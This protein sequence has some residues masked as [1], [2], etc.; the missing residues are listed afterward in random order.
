MLL[1]A[2]TADGLKLE[3]GDRAE[4]LLARGTRRQQLRT[5]EVAGLFTRLA[6]FP[7]GVQVVANLGFYTQATGITETD[8]FLVSTTEEGPAGQRAAA[9][10]I[11]AG[12]GAGDRLELD[13]AA[14][15]LNREQSSLTALN[16]R[17][18]LGLDAA[19]ALAMSAAVMAIFVLGLMLHRRAEFVLL[20]AQGLPAR[21]LRLLLLGEA[22]FVALAGLVVGGVAGAGLGRLLVEVLQP[23]FIR[24][25]QLT[26]AA[27]DLLG[28]VAIVLAATAV[29]V[30]AAL[31]I[32][33][34]L[35]PGE[36]LREQ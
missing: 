25:P 7:E 19:F 13:T 22:V 5:V 10:A 8:T 32:L 29:S 12:P 33:R 15:G 28:F 3:V 27:G 21:R 30:G 36:V 35:S 26:L 17:G 1:E 2:D 18:L 14:S 34:G 9:A 23:I 16:V 6:G 4:L 11:A 31:A 24:T 20:V